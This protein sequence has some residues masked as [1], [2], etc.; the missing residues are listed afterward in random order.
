MWI[1][2]ANVSRHHTD[3]LTVINYYR[4]IATGMDVVLFPPVRLSYAGKTD[5]M[6]YPS[7]G[8]IVRRNGPR[9]ICRKNHDH[10]VYEG[11]PNFVLEIE[12]K[13]GFTDLGKKRQ[14][15]EASGVQEA[16][17]VEN[18][19]PATWY[20]LRGGKFEVLGQEPAG[21]IESRALPGFVLDFEKFREHRWL[22]MMDDI[23][24][25]V[26]K[27]DVKRELTLEYGL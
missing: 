18:G 15:Y 20:Q 10:Q 24:E 8:V 6:V 23:R 7:V 1:P 4:M 9:Q 2:D 14:I 21:R 25:S 26:E 3:V 17:F 5:V 13:H 11:P 22:A 27:T 19:K 16:L 12:S